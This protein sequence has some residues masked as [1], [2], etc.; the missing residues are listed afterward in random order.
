M[1]QKLTLDSSILSQVGGLDAQLEVCDESSRVVGYLLP[2]ELHRELM[3]AWA[4]TQFTDEESARARAELKSQPGLPTADA[5]AYLER[6]AGSA[7][8]AP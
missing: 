1:M 6:L 4:R 2:P 8:S 7:G 3:Y 5:I